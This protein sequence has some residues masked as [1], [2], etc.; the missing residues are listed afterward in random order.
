M[1]VRAESFRIW[2]D[3]EWHLAF[4]LAAAPAVLMLLAV[5]MNP[6]LVLAG[7]V[8]LACVAVALVRPLAGFFCY[9]LEAQFVDYFK[10]LLLAFGNPS[11]IEWY[12]VILLPDLILFAVLI[13]I[14]VNRGVSVSGHTRKYYAVAL[15]LYLYASWYSVRSIWTEAPVVNSVG[16]WKLVVP[17]FVCFYI[18]ERLL[19]NKDLLRSMLKVLAG[20]CAIAS[21][22]GLYQLVFGLTSFE[23]RWL[24]QGY[25]GLDVTTLIYGEG[26][27]R[28][29]SFFSDANTFGTALACVGTL[30][31]F[32]RRVYGRHWWNS[33]F[34][35]ILMGAALLATVVRA[36]WLQAVLGIGTYWW[37]RS[38]AST[39]RK[40]GVVLIL[41]T[42]LVA[43]AFW[44]I[45]TAVNVDVPILARAVTVGTYDARTTGYENLLELHMATFVLGKGV[46]TLPG[47]V[48]DISGTG[49][50][51]ELIAHDFVSELLYEVG[52]I[53]LGLFAFV[54]IRTLI[55]PSPQFLGG[56]TP[57]L[58][59]LVWSIPLVAGLFGGSLLVVRPVTS[60]LWVGAGM[61]CAPDSTIEN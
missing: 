14:F 8:T 3:A 37:V 34:L 43:G 53:G 59:Y 20:G 54:V 51:T 56:M 5:A 33:W 29:F 17:Y 40:I 21:L 28:A 61:L 36:A 55:G 45:S 23:D 6:S 19:T 49:V 41:A 58:K 9:L 48:K 12:G 13:G 27:T 39:T 57:A 31:I 10:R 47:S 44:L 7:I 46:G 50:D 52:W 26:T 32:S 60:V 2:G 35:L 22:Y 18:G 25:T 38:R 16:K 4:V 11:T 1:S 30:L 42:V 15:G 24:F